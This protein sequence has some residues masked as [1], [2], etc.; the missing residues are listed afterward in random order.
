M[1]PNVSAWLAT[2]EHPSKQRM[3]VGTSP[4]LVWHK[5]SRPFEAQKGVTSHCLKE[6]GLAA[7]AI[8]GG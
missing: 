1:L 3:R 2:C 7:R 6:R 5:P 4:S 8:G